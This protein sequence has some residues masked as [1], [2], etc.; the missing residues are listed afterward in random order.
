MAGFLDRS[1]NIG[2][3]DRMNYNS[4]VLADKM[5]IR[6]SQAPGISAE[7]PEFRR[8]VPEGAMPRELFNYP[9][10]GIF[11]QGSNQQQIQPQQQQIIQMPQQMPMQSN[12]F[13]N[14][15]YNIAG[16]PDIPIATP[17]TVIGQLLGDENVPEEI[18]KKYWF[19]F[20]KDTTL[21]FL[22][23]E[24]KQSKL[25]NMDIIKIDILNSIPYY[26][27]TF[28][29]E[30]ELNILRNIYE[31]K[32]DRAVGFG[33]DGK[34]ASAKNERTILQSQFTES[35]QIHEDAN[36]SNIRQGFFQKLFGKRT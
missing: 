30:L 10:D 14:S 33:H 12:P 31:T 27:Y 20:N 7:L 9:Q 16:M 32:L 22:D 18:L 23:N 6:M 3:K 2:I 21:T 15:G 26:D 4:A 5:G 29:R 28:E 24:R 13:A 17:P 11:P 36:Q 34:S 8:D 35:R 25:L 1:A 19:I